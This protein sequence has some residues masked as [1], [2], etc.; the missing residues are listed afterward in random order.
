[1]YR[2]NHRKRGT[3]AVSLVPKF[4][5]VL[6]VQTCTWGR[7]QKSSGS[8][9]L[10]DRPPTPTYRTHTDILTLSSG[11]QDRLCGP[12]HRVLHSSALCPDEGVSDKAQTGEVDPGV[13]RQRVCVFCFS[14]F[15]GCKTFIDTYHRAT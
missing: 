15:P 7:G 5:F 3:S 4:T 14:L 10:P 8:A 2:S 12:A 1:M 9:K 11:T 6:I 13:Q